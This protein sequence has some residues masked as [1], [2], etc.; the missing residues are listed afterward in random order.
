MR[1]VLLELEG[2]ASFRERT[3]VDF[4]DAD[5]FAL[6]G[7]TGAGKSTVVDAMTFA[8]FGS[9]PRW[10]R[11]NA[12][13]YALAPTTARATVR[14]VFELAGRRYVAAREVRRTGAAVSMRGPGTRPLLIA[15]RRPMST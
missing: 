1:P 12:V 13:S 8:L 15:L 11:R 7:P 4:R 2:F 9:A 6:V 5:Y 3:V 10:G 14:L